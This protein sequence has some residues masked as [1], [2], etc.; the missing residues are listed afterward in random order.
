MKARLRRLANL[1]RVLGPAT[2]VV[3]AVALQTGAGD[4][5]ALEGGWVPCSDVAAV[6]EQPGVS[7]KEYLGFDPREIFA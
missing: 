3:T 2:P 7:E 4:L 6:L 5:M 1:E